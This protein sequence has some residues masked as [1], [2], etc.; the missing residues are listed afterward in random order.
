MTLLFFSPLLL[1]LL[2]LA[3][4]PFVKRKPVALPL[5]SLAPYATLPASWRERVSRFH[6]LIAA[7]GLLLLI[8][9]LSEPTLE[10]KSQ[11]T[12]RRGVNLML[13]LDIS[14]SMLA[15]DIKPSRIEVARQTAADF[16]Q[17][18]Q[19]DKIGIILF[20]GVSFLLAPPT[21]DPAPIIDRLLRIEPD[22]IGSGTAI[23]DALA[24]ATARLPQRQPQQIGESAV[25]LLTDGKSNRGR[26]TPIT[27]ARAAAALNVRVYTI[28]FG[29]LAGAFLPAVAGNQPEKVVLDEE[30]LLKIA[31]LTGGRY[32][33]ATD[34]TE[35]EQVY[36]QIDSLEKT[37]LEIRQQ[38]E[39]EPLQPLLLRLAALLL[40]LELILF[41]IGLRRGP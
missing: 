22:K 25:I 23:G 40:T 34:A 15:D 36:Q 17:R 1:L 18:R 9:A 38:L 41:R 28:G 8:T 7:L 26:I 16:I 12:L 33:R 24:A 29:S 2:P 3:L 37:D 39:H 6:P 19:N 20:S 14:A 11:L 4:L 10:K 21:D 32:F 5:S 30:P 31:E 13:A 27:A 35:L